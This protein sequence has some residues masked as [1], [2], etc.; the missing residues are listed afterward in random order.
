MSKRAADHHA[1]TGGAKMTEDEMSHHIRD[2]SF[3]KHAWVATMK[4]L[5]RKL[6]EHRQNKGM[7]NVPVDPVNLGLP[8]YTDIVKNPMDLGTVKFRLESNYYTHHEDV[9]SDIRQVYLNAITFNGP[10]FFVS[11][12]AKK[13]LAIFEEDYLKFLNDFKDP[14][15]D[16]DICQLC[17]LGCIEFQQPVLRC[18]TPCKARI[19]R[20]ATYYRLGG[21]RGQHWCSKCYAMLPDRFM[22]ILGMFVYKSDLEERHHN[23]MFFEKWVECKSC[24][25]KVH[26]ICGLSVDC[27]QYVCPICVAEDCGFHV[28]F[29]DAVKKAAARV[30]VAQ[31]EIK[32]YRAVDLPRSLMGDFLEEEI[33]KISEKVVSKEFAASLTVRV[34]SNRN[35]ITRYEPRIL[36]WI[37]AQRR[38]CGSLYDD[39]H[40]AQVFPCR[41]KTI[42]LFQAVDG[43]DIILF[44]LYVQ[45][46][47]HHCQPPN[48][49]KVYISYLDSV[50]F[51]NPLTSRT[52]VYQC[53]MVSYIR[54]VRARGFSDVYIWACP[55]QRGDA[56]IFYCHPKWQRTPG[57]ERL[58]KW[59]GGIVHSCKTMG[60]VQSETN[61]YKR[62][63]PYFAP[64]LNTRSSR[65]PKS[66]SS[67]N[68]KNVALF[69]KSQSNHSNNKKIK[70]SIEEIPYFYGDYLPNEIESMFALL[71]RTIESD[72]M[73]FQSSNDESIKL[74]WQ[75][76]WGRETKATLV[77]RESV[78][79]ISKLH[80]VVS[81]VKCPVWKVDASVDLD[82]ADL[83]VGHASPQQRN[84]WFMRKLAAAV[85][86][87]SE[88]FLVLKLLPT[89]M[90]PV[91]LDGKVKLVPD[92][93]DPD[94]ELPPGLFDVRMEFLDLCKFNNFQFDELRRVKHSSLV[95]MMLHQQA[96][97]ASVGSSITVKT[98]V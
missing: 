52:M 22:A 48:H 75:S 2:L 41:S 87:L 72:E 45:E 74:W 12:A 13:G 88:N 65:L 11:I 59:Y 20:N 29:P 95:I 89:G 54:W 39:E 5:C 56:Y 35:S 16:E 25:R 80:G 34:V 63:L 82:T 19:Q 40:L 15:G 46:Y 43:I 18:S 10:K 93:S 55:P 31:E 92:T 9:A 58:R 53:L 68:S 84:D 14:V 71:S 77:H 27:E 49:N 98:H 1:V 36:R 23:Q 51:L 70:H 30:P 85:K 21:D 33:K 42:T 62:H 76:V 73:R 96:L 66:M 67:P 60:V 50:P 83:Q 61:L 26:E 79:F 78:E 81:P 64:L 44:V 7:F 57:V 37:Q 38:S 24:C 6:M 47:G 8:T 3:G 32:S 17:G 86:P 91:E 28:E 90:T 97:A 94:P 69:L 4:L